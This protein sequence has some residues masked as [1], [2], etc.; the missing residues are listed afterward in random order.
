[1]ARAGLV[2]G[3]AF[4]ETPMPQGNEGNDEEGNAD[5]DNESGDEEEPE[6]FEDLEETL[7]DGYVGQVVVLRDTLVPVHFVIGV[8][9]VYV[10]GFDCNEIAEIPKDVLTA[11][12]LET[13]LSENKDDLKQFLPFKPK[14]P[15]RLFICIDNE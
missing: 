5:E 12:H 6:Y 8:L 2:Y 1:M 13:V 3:W 4:P 7:L 14:L 9:L 11:D 15:P 10:G